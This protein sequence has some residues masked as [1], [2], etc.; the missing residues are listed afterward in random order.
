MLMLNSFEREEML[1]NFTQDTI[2]F[3]PGHQNSINRKN[4]ISIEIV[5]PTSSTYYQLFFPAF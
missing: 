1:K 3:K 4:V 2:K 5:S